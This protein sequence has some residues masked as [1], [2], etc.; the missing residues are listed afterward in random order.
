MCKIIEE[1]EITVGIKTI[2]F[3]IKE[4]SSG[5]YFYSTSH[6]YQG[7]SQEKPYIS[8]RNRFDSEEKAIDGAIKQ[9]VTFYDKNDEN[10]KDNWIINYLY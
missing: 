9:I 1:Y 3:K 7:P 2:K 8:S 4:D 10:E 5:H 6:Y